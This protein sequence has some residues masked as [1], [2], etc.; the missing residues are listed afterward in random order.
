[1][2]S[3]SLYAEAFNMLNGFLVFRFIYF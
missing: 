2:D 1:M 3:Y